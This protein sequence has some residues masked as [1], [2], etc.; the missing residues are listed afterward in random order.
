HMLAVLRICV[1]LEWASKEG[2]TFSSS[3]V[4]C[5]LPTHMRGFLH[6]CVAGLGLEKSWSHLGLARRDSGT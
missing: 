4:S 2:V 5:W 1:A 3:N 6:L